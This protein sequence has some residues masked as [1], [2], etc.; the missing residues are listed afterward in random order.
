[1]EDLVLY[2]F[3]S[4]FCSEVVVPF[5]QLLFQG[6]AEKLLMFLPPATPDSLI[7]NM[8]GIYVPSISGKQSIYAFPWNTVK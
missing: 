8:C 2:K 6:S 5:V 4:F 7:K 1:M 3:L